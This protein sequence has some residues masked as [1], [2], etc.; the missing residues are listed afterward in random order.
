MEGADYPLQVVT[1]P[2]PPGVQTASGIIEI[3]ND[4]IVE[5]PTEETFIAR[6]NSPE[7]GILA[8]ITEAEVTIEDDDSKML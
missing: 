5:T 6:L 2:F 8:G 4:K 7:Q 1:I 3:I